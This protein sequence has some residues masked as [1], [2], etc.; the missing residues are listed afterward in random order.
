MQTNREYCV[1]LQT[2][3]LFIAGV[4]ILMYTRKVCVKC[5]SH[6]FFD[7]SDREFLKFLLKQLAYHSGKF[8]P[9]EIKF[10]HGS[11]PGKY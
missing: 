11:N 10:L 3:I 2:S 9:R 5:H 6:E 4:Q 7:C 8:A 1:S